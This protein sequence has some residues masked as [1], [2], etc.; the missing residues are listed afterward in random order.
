M[1]ID[2]SKI[3]VISSKKV[4]VMDLIDK[5]SFAADTNRKAASASTEA[6]EA[7]AGANQGYFA[8]MWSKLG[9]PFA[10]FE[11]KRKCNACCC[12]AGMAISFPMTMCLSGIVTFGCIFVE[13][14]ISYTLNSAMKQIVWIS[15]PGVA[16]GGTLHYFVSEA[17]WSRSK[18]TWGT[19]WAKAVAMNSIMWAMIIGMGTLCWRK[20]LPRTRVGKRIFHSY[21]CP[22]DSIEVR[23]MRNK[24]AFF[25]SMDML[26]FLSGIGSGQAGYIGAASMAVQQDKMH[27]L[28]NPEGGYGRACLPQW[29]LDLIA[30]K[31][32][33]STPKAPLPD[34]KQ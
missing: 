7:A 9:G 17:M 13:K 21:N 19:A 11:D 28:M 15:L 25:T 22:T 27:F 29:R 5:N 18:N 34:S 6:A 24:D 26:Y 8:M 3:S 1:P 30:K 32:N 20:L 23:Q 2:S 4:E 14:R 16:C 10:A 33:F 31:A 12:I